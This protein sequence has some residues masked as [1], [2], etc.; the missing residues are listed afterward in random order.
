MNLTHHAYY[1]EGQTSDFE[2]YAKRIPH[3]IAEKFERFGIDEA[4]ELTGRASLKK[5]GDQSV[6]LLAAQSITSEAQQ[7]LLK[8]FEEPQQGIVFVFLLPH[9]ALLPTLR[10]RM[11]SLPQELLS[12]KS[13]GSS[14]SGA[15][16]ATPASQT[17]SE[18]AL[19][20]LQSNGKARSDLVAKL[21][22]D[23]DDTKERVRDLLLGLEAVLAPRIAEP[24]VR[25]GLEDI[26][27]VRSY[28]GD[29]SPALKMLLEHLALSL[30]KL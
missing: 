16:R 18:E 21:L 2:E 24:E 3:F 27:K 1:I 14:S 29:R 8:L 6:F 22:K 7:A 30:P 19:A 23:E 15:L 4:R 5:T 10:S 9:G 11:L 26:A 25:E 28:V 12:K 20:F 17:F 13:S